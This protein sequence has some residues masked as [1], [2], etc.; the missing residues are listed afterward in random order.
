M[1]NWFDALWKPSFQPSNV[2]HVTKPF[3]YSFMFFESTNRHARCCPDLRQTIWIF[4][5]FNFT[6]FTF[7]DLEHS[8]YFC[9]HLTDVFGSCLVFSSVFGT[10][11]INLTV[12]NDVKGFSVRHKFRWLGKEIQVKWG[13]A[14]NRRYGYFFR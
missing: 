11:K 4:L 7:I 12:T 3:Q 10:Y 9:L 6:L 13:S 14:R 8:F 5:K 1:K 2:L